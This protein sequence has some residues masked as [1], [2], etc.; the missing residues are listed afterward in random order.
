MIRT[1]SAAELFREGADRAELARLNHP[2]LTRPQREFAS[3]TDRFL[4]WDGG[5]SIG[6][7]YGHA[8]DLVHFTR[9]SHPW[10][11]VPIGPRKVMVAGFSFAQMDPL[12]EKLWMMLPKGEVDPKLYYQPG[13]GI[14]GFKERVI[15]FVAGPG[16]GSVIYL[17]TY[18]QGPQRIM[19]FQ[20]HRL[21]MDEP[22]PAPVYAEA[23]PRLNTYKGELRITMTPTP[24]SPPLEYLRKELTDGHIR[25]MKTSYN[26]ENITVHGGLVPW[27]WKLQADIDE[28]I[29]SYLPDERPMREHG[30]F[31]PLVAGRWLERFTEENI[32]DA[33]LP[34]DVGWYLAVAVDHGT[35]PGREWATLCAGSTDGDYWIVDESHVPGVTTM[36]EDARGILVMLDRNGLSW[37]DVDHWIGDRATSES[38]YGSAKSNSDLQTELA[39]LLGLSRQR[40][41]D[42]GLRFK[43][44]FKDRGSVRRGFQVMNTMAARKRLHVRRRCQGFIQGARSFAG[45]MN[46]EEKDPLDSAR[47]GLLTLHDR[48]DV[49]KIG[50][51]GRI[52]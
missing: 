33:D 39:A 43:T 48:A 52:Q 5:N 41:A 20:G 13:Q 3:A 14:M 2:R 1:R 28:D 34:G 11:S 19:G 40:A 21:S 31:D 37:M 16:R 32:T 10:R 27:P 35:R 25:M 42:G 44:M 26:Q 9:G 18:E 15:P 7:S 38:F 36:A 23:R 49:R 50:T 22:P 12:M 6:K 4:L 29:A 8:F 17:T 51:F 47:Y 24:E 30:D 45:D 46:A